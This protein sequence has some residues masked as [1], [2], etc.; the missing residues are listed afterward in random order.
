MEQLCIETSGERN[1]QSVGKER[2]GQELNWEGGR[3]G[4]VDMIR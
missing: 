1:L 2:R 3:R 4:R